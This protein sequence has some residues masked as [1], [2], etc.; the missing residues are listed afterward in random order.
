MKTLTSPVGGE[1]DRGRVDRAV[2][3][4]PRCGR[5]RADEARVA[6]G[7][8]RVALVGAAGSRGRSAAPAARAPPASIRSVWVTPSASRKGRER[9]NSSLDRRRAAVGDQLGAGGRR[10]PAAGP[11]RRRGTRRGARPRPRSRRRLAVAAQV[12][13][14]RPL[15][16]PAE[17]RRRSSW[18]P[19]C[20]PGCGRRR[21]GRRTRRRPWRSSAPRRGGRRPCRARRR[22]SAPPARARSGGRGRRGR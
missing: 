7:G 1:V 16:L 15:V 9:K 2:G 4:T 19:R 6:V 8:D 3:S 21:G 22:R 10:S 5:P 18:R 14:H 12:A 11:P 13:A 17:A 20:G